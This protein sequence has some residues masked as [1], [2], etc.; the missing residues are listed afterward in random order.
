MSVT[1]Q[2]GSTRQGKGQSSTYLGGSH[3]IAIVH[4]HQ[5]HLIHSIGHAQGNPGHESGTMEQVSV[6]AAILSQSLL[7]VGA[8]GPFPFLTHS[9]KR[10]T[11]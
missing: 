11:G 3:F 9:L 5:V 4:R 2:C 10:N 1:L 8:T 7:V 6:Q